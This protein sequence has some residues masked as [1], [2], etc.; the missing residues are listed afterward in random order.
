MPQYDHMISKA[1]CDLVVMAFDTFLLI[2]TIML[3]MTV[4]DTPTQQNILFLMADQMRADALNIYGNKHALTPNLDRLAKEGVWFKHGMSSTPTCTPARAAILTGQKPWNHGML[5]Y[6]KIALKYPVEMPR[7]LQEA[8]YYTASKGKDHFGWDPDR[9]HSYAHGYKQTQIYDGLGQFDTASPTK[10]FGEYDDYDQWFQQQLP[11][12]DP[13]ATLDSLDGDGWNGWQG[14]TY[15]YDEYYHP[16]AWVGRAAVKFIRNYKREQPFFLKVSFHRPHSPY[17]P[18]HRVF[19]LIKDR[20][21]PPIHVGDHWDEIF[22]TDL[23]NCGSA[24]PDAWCGKMP[25]SMRNNSRLCYAASVT[26]VDE[27]IGRIMEAL[28]DRGMLQNTFIL[29]T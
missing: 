12:F 14:R 1:N 11:G 25:E 16:T 7:I 28:S 27:Q 20:G 5:G 26:F 23:E 9:N 6:G 4:A 17:D 2:F 3:W 19:E 10:W 15:V 29:F 22:A 24:F 21:L 18:P 8:G 13:Q